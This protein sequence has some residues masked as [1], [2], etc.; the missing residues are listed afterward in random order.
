MLCDFYP[1]EMRPIIAWFACFV[2][3]SYNEEKIETA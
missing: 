1:V 3:L 2:L